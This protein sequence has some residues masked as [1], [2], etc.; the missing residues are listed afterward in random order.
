MTTATLTP[1]PLPARPSTAPSSGP[2][3]KVWTVD[4]FHDL[5]EHGFLEGRGAKLMNGVIVEEGPMNHPHATAATKTED[6]VREAFGRAW[7]VR[8]SKPLVFGQTTD[9]QPDV[10]VVRG[11][12]GDYSAHPTTADLVVEVSDSSL[13]YDLTEKLTAYAA[14]GIADYWVLDVT[15]RQLHVFR[16]PSGDAYATHL[17]LG[18]SESVA[19]LA[20]PAATVRVADLLP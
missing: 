14:A 12:P 15:G 1:P 5:G 11:R 2:A 20:A 16:G 17:T 8:V 7:H 10:A 6:S 18:E 3:P 13:R 19:P 9:P 4:E